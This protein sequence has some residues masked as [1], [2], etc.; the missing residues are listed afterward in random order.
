MFRN[1][2]QP[3]WYP[4]LD[5]KHRACCVHH[6]EIRRAGNVEQSPSYPSLALVTELPGRLSLTGNYP[7]AS[8]KP[9]GKTL[10]LNHKQN[11]PN[12]ENLRTPENLC[13]DNFIEILSI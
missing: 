4:G 10:R 6:W 7:G 8:A 3:E 1:T 12:R 13:N 2:K 11:K 9:F 5:Y